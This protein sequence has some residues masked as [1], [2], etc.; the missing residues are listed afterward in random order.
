MKADQTDFN[1]NPDPRILPMLG[2]I[3]LAQ[4]RCLAELID[5]AI[6]GFLSAARSGQPTSHPEVLVNVPMTDQPSS[7]IA[8]VDNGP[9]MSPEVLERAVSA[10]WSG[11]NPVD[12]L[13]MFGMGF[14]IATA[15]LG[16]VTTVW[17]SRAG[18]TEECGLRIDFAE[19]LGTR[20]FRTPRLSRP[21]L[22]PSSSGTEV[23]IEG[24][25]P[26]QRIWFSRA[27]N[28]SA[29]REELSKA[30]SAM[31]RDNGTPISFKLMYG[32][33]RMPA[34]AHC[35]WDESRQTQTSRFGPV[36]AIQTID[37]R[38]PDR[39]F[40]K[41]CW[42]WLSAS[43]TQCPAC[44]SS[45]SVI[46]RKRHVHGWIGLQ[47]FLSATNYGVDFI[48]NGRKI[49]IAN[50]DLFTWKDPVT[51]ASEIE[52]PIDDPRQRGRIVGEIHLDH[53]RV[54]YMK[55]RFDRT[56]PAWD[57]MVGIVRGEGPLQPN[58][59]AS[60]GFGN[61]DSPLFKL[62][63]TY[64]RSSPKNRAAGGWQDVLVVK[65]NDRAEEMA[66]QYQ[67]GLAVY[68][69]DTKWWDLIVEEDN[70]LLTGGRTG[71]SSGAGGGPQ[72]GLS[73]FG[74]ASGS[75]NAAAAP[76]A[77]ATTPA[78]LRTPIASLTR[79][80]RHDA[81][82]LRY[83]VRAFSV[84]P[85]DPELS[86]SGAPWATK[87]T[88]DGVFS[89]LMNPAHEI[90]RSATM[91]EL[92]ALLCELAYRTADFSRQGTTAPPFASI[93][94]DFRNS[95]GESLKLDGAAI[96][97]STEHLFR[98]IA[99]T[100]SIG[101]DAQTAN[102]LF[103]EIPSAD[104]EAIQHRMAARSV[105]NPQQV[106]AEGRFLEFAPP[107]VAA[108]FV[109]THPE[110]FF[111]GKCWEDAYVHLDFMHP[112]ATES[113]RSGVVSKYEALLADAVWLSEQDAAD[114]DATSRERVLRA[115]LAIDLLA[116]SASPE[117]SEQT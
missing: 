7:R 94:A 93:L 89:F 117:R 105:A 73:G 92:D 70:K 37:R 79:E 67:E 24:I 38:L 40:C 28:R 54:T 96:L 56:D 43:E 78:P 21:K 11:N 60:Q 1:L 6:D 97:A 42:Q 25:K 98:S 50:R 27:P 62:Y 31:L 15:R 30:Y 49:E 2:E 10:G 19:L 58:K 69:P 57:E 32:G 115:S 112:A 51:G 16:T 81:T 41:T 88:P 68:Q 114:L 59:A 23:V 35:V 5:N 85:H 76:N 63:Q 75:P 29:I 110:F 101:L 102:Q 82:S 104:G 36:S 77:S 4:W 61:N 33:K 13:G 17:T 90:F 95:Y 86:P 99:R 80:Y 44:S 22:D 47:R 74:S 103:S 64:R 72:G 34:R 100:W 106:V 39:P 14:N 108:A 91:T 107:R 111:D 9:G 18:E 3:N 48:R 12:S 66:K 26:D 71:A 113:A 116:P 20:H 83:D 46:M 8:V 53:S 55:D 87:R 109:V 84:S 65:D 45:A 52:Y